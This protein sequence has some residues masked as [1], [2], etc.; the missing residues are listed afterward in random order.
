MRNQTWTSVNEN[1]ISQSLVW[2]VD[3]PPTWSHFLSSTRWLALSAYQLS[4]N[5]RFHFIMTVNSCTHSWRFYL[6]KICWAWREL[7]QTLALDWTPPLMRSHQIWSTAQNVIPYSHLATTSHRFVSALME[8][9]VSSSR[10]N[11]RVWFCLEQVHLYTACWMT[12]AS[13]NKLT[14][15]SS[16]A[17]T[18]HL[19]RA[20]P[21]RSS[22]FLSASARR[23]Q[24]ERKKW[25]CEQKP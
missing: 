25:E 8:F 15:R 16:H 14:C 12:R 20:G 4:L 11:S 7:I 24:E 21:L 18:R 10:A 2:P 1:S 9:D 23:A 3:W 5:S 22:R 13:D 17:R 6:L 19:Q